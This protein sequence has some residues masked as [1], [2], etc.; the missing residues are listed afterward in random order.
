MLAPGLEF[1]YNAFNTLSS[2]R[3]IGMAE[4]RIPW[5]AANEFSLRYGLND[6]ELDV[7]W[8]LISKMDSAYLEW[9]SKKTSKDTPIAPNAGK[10]REVPRSR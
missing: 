9:Q 1:Y 5:T 3:P 8:S 6:V 7:L 10:K 4:G 2:C